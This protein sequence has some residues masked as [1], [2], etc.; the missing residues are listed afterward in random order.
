MLVGS[1]L[2]I[3]NVDCNFKNM[4]DAEKAI[5]DHE[6]ETYAKFSVCSTHGHFFEKG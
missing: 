2:D 6:I 5:E 1:T 4:K 3:F